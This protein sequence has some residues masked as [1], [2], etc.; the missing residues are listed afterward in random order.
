MN[1]TS[2]DIQN[3]YQALSDSAALSPDALALAFEDRRYLYRDFHLRV[4]R[5]IAQLDHDWSLR[6][7]HRILLASG[8]SPRF[9]RSPFCRAGFGH[10]SGAFQHQA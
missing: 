4:Q 10:R 3:L 7:E 8:Q 5:T 9:L 6:K 1:N 2:A